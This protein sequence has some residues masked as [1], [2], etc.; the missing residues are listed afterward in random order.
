MK[1]WIVTWLDKQK[2]KTFELFSLQKELQM[3]GSFDYHEFAMIINQLVQ[4]GLIQPIDN[5]GKNHRTDSLF[6]K[7]KRIVNKNRMARADIDQLLLLYHPSMKVTYYIN[8]NNEYEVDQPFL[9]AI[10]NFLTNAQDTS[11]L[12]VNERSYELVGNEKWLLANGQ[13]LLNKIGLTLSDL[14]CEI[15]HEPFFYYQ[16]PSWNKKERVNVLII[17]NKDTFGSMKRLFLRDLTMFFNTSFDLLIYG[18]GKKIGKS[19]ESI[20]DIEGARF[21]KIQG[22]YFGDLDP[23]GINIFLHLHKKNVFPIIPFKEMY[24]A[25][26]K[27][28]A[29]KAKPRQHAQTFREDD[30]IEFLRY[31]DTEYHQ[32]TLG[33]LQSS[34]IPQESLNRKILESMAIQ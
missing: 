33:L 5:S 4:E 24:E 6:N 26:I 2:S 12:S 20:W 17:E 10:N 14:R 15:E 23:V 8:R 19:I 13:K 11:W 34:Y 31:L 30:T 1:Q 3:I 25:M 29:S 22:Y 28:F 9:Q 32:T 18:E 16:C 7:Y 21:K 27:G